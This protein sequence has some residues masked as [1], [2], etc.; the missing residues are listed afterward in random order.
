[1]AFERQPTVRP[2]AILGLNV[3]LVDVPA[4][5]D[6]EDPEGAG[7]TPA[8]KEAWY[9]IE[10]SMSD[11]S[12]K[13]L[14]GDLVPHLSGAQITGLMDFMTDVRAKAEAEIF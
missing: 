10:V 9:R 5:G 6:A 12:I 14:Q 1:V 11:G 3:T 7:Y 8:R 13:T 2:V 4:R